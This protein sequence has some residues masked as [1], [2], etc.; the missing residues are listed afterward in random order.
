MNRFNA[1]QLTL[2]ARRKRTVTIR[3][4]RTRIVAYEQLEHR[5]LLSADAVGNV[6]Q[7][8]RSIDVVR[9]TWISMSEELNS[10]TDVDVYSVRLKAGDILVTATHTDP[11]TDIDTLI[12]VFDASGKELFHQDNYDGLDATLQFRAVQDGTFYIGVS[13]TDNYAYNPLHRAVD[14]GL[15]F[16]SYDIDFLVHSPDADQLT[17]PTARQV[18]MDANR[19]AM[20]QS[21]IKSGADVDFFSVHAN[22]GDILDVDLNSYGLAGLDLYLKVF[23]GNGTLLS[24]NDDGHT[25]AL[26]L[27]DPAKRLYIKSTDTYYL[28]I[29]YW[30]NTGYDPL[31]GIGRKGDAKTFGYYELN[32]SVSPAALDDNDTIPTAKVVNVDPGQI[33][34]IEGRIDHE[35]DVDFYSIALKGGES[36][37][38][39]TNTKESL[40]SDSHTYLQPYVQIYDATGAILAQGHEINSHK[41]D[42]D[43]QLTFTPTADGMYF[44]AISD[45]YHG[46]FDPFVPLSDDYK[47]KGT[48][49]DYKLIVD[50]ARP[51][52]VITDFTLDEAAAWGDEVHG[53]ITIKN[54]GV[55]GTGAF[56]VNLVAH[57]AG[58]SEVLSLGTFSFAGLA[59]DKSVT[60]SLTVRLESSTPHEGGDTVL[61]IDATVDAEDEN[62]ESDETNN[63]TS[64]TLRAISL[65]PHLARVGLNA[66]V[67]VD[68]IAAQEFVIVAT[69]SG[70][71]TVSTTGNGRG[72]VDPLLTLY[73]AN[74]S[75]LFQSDNRG[76]GDDGATLDQYVTPGLYRISVS[77]TPTTGNVDILTSFVSSTLPLQPVPFPLTGD[78]ELDAITHGDFNRDGILDLVAIDG[79]GSR[80]SLYEGRRDGTF[81]ARGIPYLGKELIESVSVADLDGNGTA[82]LII[83]ESS[84]IDYIGSN[85]LTLLLGNG[86]GT[87]AAPTVIQRSI[88]W[89][90]FVQSGDFNGDGIQDVAVIRYNPANLTSEIRLVL[91]GLNRDT[92]TES[93]DAI[94]FDDGVSGVA[95]ADVDRD[96]ISDL[97]IIGGEHGIIVYRGATN[98]PLASQQQLNTESSFPITVAAADFDRDGVDDFAVS[99]QDSRAVDIF[100]GGNSTDLNRTRT[101]LLAPFFDND[102]MVAGDFDGDGHADLLVS[103]ITE[104]GGTIF[105]GAAN[106]DLSRKSTFNARNFLG[107]GTTGD[108]NGDGRDDIAFIGQEQLSISL[109]RADGTFQDPSA[110]SIR[111]RVHGSHAGLVSA[112]FNNDGVM[113][114]ATANVQ[115]NAIS[116]LLGSVGGAFD[117]V[118]EYG[119]ENTALDIL[120]GDFNHDGRMDIVAPFLAANDDDEMDSISVLLGNGDGTFQ[121]RRYRDTGGPAAIEAADFDHDGILDLVVGH[122]VS[123][124]L[125]IL[126]GKRDGTFRKRQDLTFPVGISILQLAV[127]DF[128]HDGL[129]DVAVVGNDLFAVFN[130]DA[131]AILR[132]P[133]SAYSVAGA[134]QVKTGDFNGDGNLDVVIAPGTSDSDVISVLLGDGAGSFGPTN[135]AGIPQN[136]FSDLGVASDLFVLDANADGISD[137]TTANS[138]ANTV[139]I[140]LG[141]RN[142]IMRPVAHRSLPT[143]DSFALGDFNNDGVRDL[144]VGIEGGKLDLLIGV[145]TDELFVNDTS[146]VNSRS[147]SLIHEDL[148]KDGVV[149]LAALN[150]RGDILVRLGRV[151]AGSSQNGS[152]RFDAPFILNAAKNGAP[153]KQI[154]LL[155]DRSTPS[156]DK[157]IAALDAAN[158]SIRVYSLDQRNIPRHRLTI[159]LPAAARPSQLLTTDLN[160]DDRDDLVVFLSGT[161]QIIAYLATS[162][163]FGDSITLAG[164]LA[165]ASRVFLSDVDDNG[166][167]DLLVANPTSGVVKVLWSAG[168]GTFST[169]RTYRS[170]RNPPTV[171]RNASDETTLLSSDFPTSVA[172]ADINEDGWLDVLVG[173]RGTNSYSIL[174][175]HGGN[176]LVDPISH[177]LTNP[178]TQ[179]GIEP[180]QLITGNFSDD[181]SDGVTD[182]N[183]HVDIAFLDDVTGKLFVYL[184]DGTGDLAPISESLD[185]GPGAKAIKVEDLD[186]DGI[187]DLLIGNESGDTLFLHGKG[188]GSFE[189]YQRVGGRV[190]I[191]VADLDG[192]GRDDEVFGSESLDKVTVVY[193][194]HKQSTDFRRNGANNLLGPTAVKAIDINRDGR[195]D[196]VIANSGGNSVLVYLGNRRGGFSAPQSFFVGTQPSSIAVADLNKDG[197]LDLAVANHGSNDVSILLGKRVT[198]TSQSR[199]RTAS[200]ESAASQWT[201]TNGP[202][203]NAGNGPIDIRLGDVTG[204]N[205]KP[206]GVPDLIVTN[207]QSNNVMMIQGLGAG[208]FSDSAPQILNTAD[209]PVATLVLTGLNAGLVTIYRDSNQI[210]LFAGFRGRQDISTGDSTPVLGATSDFNRDSVDDLLLVNSDSTAELLLGDA[211]GFQTQSQQTISGLLVPTDLALVPAGLGY[212][213]YVAS[214]GSEASVTFTV[215]PNGTLVTEIAESLPLTNFNLPIVATLLEAAKSTTTVLEVSV[216]MLDTLLIANQPVVSV[217]DGSA[218][219]DLDIDESPFTQPEPKPQETLDPQMEFQTFVSGV[220]EL[221][222]ETL[223]SLRRESIDF[224]E[225]PAPE[226]ILKSKELE[227]SPQTSGDDLH[228]SRVAIPRQTPRLNLSWLLNTFVEDAVGGPLVEQTIDTESQMNCNRNHLHGAV[229]LREA[230]SWQ[231]L[232]SFVP[233]VELAGAVLVADELAALHAVRALQP[234]RLSRKTKSR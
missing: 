132:S 195:T 194:D 97:I 223:E 79:D 129:A 52:L 14:F 180:S 138:S 10:A 70:R 74:G 186:H 133:D 149:D 126:F 3:S 153:A 224:L 29:S 34:T 1:L 17:I 188:D 212:K 181:N 16:G 91:G 171:T 66:S 55:L 165:S 69:S 163:G 232:S 38:F 82:D 28:A 92:F 95:A 93:S 123:H 140:Y 117:L 33:R 36:Y 158:D 182:E 109:A 49:G 157:Q 13:D 207:E 201:L 148:N 135:S 219:S 227:G 145:P 76:L 47:E 44:V 161:G 137:L 9:D 106:R 104:P 102:T 152:A 80:V 154:A 23:D 61:S 18:A 96:G 139:T 144:A 90:Q 124:D 19:S 24:G 20:I 71:L 177:P 127:A 54:Q 220:S 58:S 168:D 205:R 32:L 56:S 166:V 203:L 151:D 146:F 98:D 88:N 178:E 65:I 215:G 217:D 48:F 211:R 81:T 208:F 37:D 103:N 156:A 26:R 30:T 196:L 21:D 118:A 167:D 121:E 108:W 89:I 197:L 99:Y 110:P 231:D 72:S 59:K 31:T 67:S 15:S 120:P 175:G 202:R 172:S 173:N 83:G 46:Q 179:F 221:F 131:K 113:D 164:D 63:T 111:G 64:T 45:F 39:R 27:R 147:G 8:A 150:R 225:N 192:D 199:S 78:G 86:D 50:P 233:A 42:R 187:N 234:R 189:P 228:A 209:S 87:F 107:V 101:T 53:Q 119:S 77:T 100:F 193:G 105:F 35:L 11:S 162:N 51:D 160:S 226:D 213:V 22:A 116:V 142:G 73:D 85:A 169:Q 190:A 62:S 43:S 40:Q 7:A 141:Q 191:A 200:V 57:I 12:R 176:K 136:T 68:S 206:D 230:H 130:G 185:I 125:T 2:K 210:T 214:E 84:G 25:R 60:Q 75:L 174:F 6:L 183:D 134:A 115:S 198:G 114:L 112:D 155:E 4:S 159:S 5:F 170:S 184:G 216:L 222:L 143:P 94:V 128:D 218:E 204:A 229:D 41:A 122:I